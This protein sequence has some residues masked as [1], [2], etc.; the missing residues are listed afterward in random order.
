MVCHICITTVKQELE[1]VNL[2]VV[3]ILLGEAILAEDIITEKQFNRLDQA[4]HRHGFERIKDHT[5]WIVESIKNK[6]IVKIHHD[7][8]TAMKYNWSSFLAEQLHYQYNYLSHLFSTMEGITLEQYIIRQK[9]ER[10]KEFLLYD[11][12][13][14][15]EIAFMMGYSSVAHLSNQFKRTT[16]F[17]PS[18]LKKSETNYQ[19]RVPL[20]AI[21]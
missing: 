16:G 18:E 2:H 3:K 7:K 11:E 15:S 5:G 14:L 19:N 4:L 6:V 13:S 9:I 10:V 21:Y 1:N 17:T 12:L 20:D 8:T